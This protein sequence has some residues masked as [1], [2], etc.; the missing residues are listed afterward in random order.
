[1]CAAFNL[2]NFALSRRGSSCVGGHFAAAVAPFQFQCERIS[3]RPSS[4][5]TPCT[6]LLWLW[7]WLMWQQLLAIFKWNLRHHILP[8]YDSTISF[9]GPLIN[10]TYLRWLNCRHQLLWAQTVHSSIKL[11]KHSWRVEN[12]KPAEFI[13]RTVKGK[14]S[15]VLWIIKLK[16]GFLKLKKNMKLEYIYL[17]TIY[18]PFCLNIICFISDTTYDKYINVSLNYVRSVAPFH[19]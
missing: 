14:D 16:E 10:P 1:M 7:L 11:F 2:L 3:S 12:Q 6:L 18:S 17:Y 19:I 15:R 9:C 5:P 13:L 4:V 8:F